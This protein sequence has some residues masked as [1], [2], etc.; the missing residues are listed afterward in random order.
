MEPEEEIAPFENQWEVFEEEVKSYAAESGLNEKVEVT[1]TENELLITLKDTVP[2]S[3]GR[4]DLRMEVLPV[5]KQ[6][7]AIAQTHPDSSLEVLGHTNDLPISTPEYPSNWEL[8][9]ARASQ[10][11]RYLAEQGIDPQR[12]SAQ[13]YAHFHPLLLN[14]STESRAVNRRVEIRLTGTVD[15]KGEGERRSEN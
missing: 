7:A 10:V 13:G 11:A 3:L 14:T 12:I 5:L 6:I 9:T 8:S 4:A 15:D 1:S 2:F